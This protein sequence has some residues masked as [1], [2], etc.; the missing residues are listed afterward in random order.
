MKSKTADISF[1]KNFTRLGYF[2][3]R[4]YNKIPQ[5]FFTFFFA[6]LPAIYFFN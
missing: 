3:S 4:D 1:S 6:K 5:I 2:N